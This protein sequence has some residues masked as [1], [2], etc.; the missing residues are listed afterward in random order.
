MNVL[1]ERPLLYSARPIISVGGRD[2]PALA[3][4]AISVGVRETASGLFSLE[5]TFGNWGARNG[6]VDYLYFD[7]AL[8]DFGAEIEITLGAGQ[9]IGRVFRGRITA[10]EGRFAQQRA[11]EVLVL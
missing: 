5:C 2:Q 10:L 6:Q 9:A 11:P 3:A 1:A 8:L 4:A 7:R